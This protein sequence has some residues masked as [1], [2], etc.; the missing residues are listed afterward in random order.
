ME[1]HMEDEERDTSEYQPQQPMTDEE[2]IQAL[3]ESLKQYQDLLEETVADERKVKTI[4]AGPFEF[5]GKFYYNVDGEVKYMADESVF[6]IV[7]PPVLEVGTS[8]IVCKGAIISITPEELDKKEEPPSFTLIDWSSV[9]GLA[10][11]VE[12][13][14]QAIDLPLNNAKLAK[15]LGCGD[16]KGLLL[17]GAPGCGRIKTFLN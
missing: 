4:T 8:V 9:G 13:I 3:E 5:E 6:K 10:S 12:E 7:Q 14:K 17:H 15:E 1:N 11:Q 16:F 2:K